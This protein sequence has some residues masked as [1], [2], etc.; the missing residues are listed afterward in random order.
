MQHKATGELLS[1][2]GSDLLL[3]QARLANV[4]ESCIN[5]LNHNGQPIMACKLASATGSACPSYGAGR[6]KAGEAVML[7]N[8]Q[9]A[10]VQAYFSQWGP[11]NS[12]QL[13]HNDSALIA[14]ISCQGPLQVAIMHKQICQNYA[15]CKV[16]L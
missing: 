4:K 3:G 9:S 5:S 2:L 1:S 10:E 11:V 6:D 16:C 15:H 12:C 8:A 14:L 13:A 7:Q